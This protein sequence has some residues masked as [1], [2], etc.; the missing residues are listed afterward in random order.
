MESK[1][2]SLDPAQ[3]PHARCWLLILGTIRTT[4]MTS[5]LIASLLVERF[6]ERDPGLS[7]RRQTSAYS[8]GCGGSSRRS[9]SFCFAILRSNSTGCRISPASIMSPMARCASCTTFWSF[10]SATR[11]ALKAYCPRDNPLSRASPISG[12]PRIG[13]S[14]RRTTCSAS[15][16]MGI[17]ICGASFVPTTGRVSFTEGLPIPSGIPRYSRQRRTG[18]ATAARLSEVTAYVTKGWIDK[19]RENIVVCGQ[20]STCLCFPVTI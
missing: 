14:A 9:P 18:L 10:R 7:S 13:M 5:A 2:E 4:S 17:R 8:C 15:F 11:F 6:G 20:I 1:I 12:R 16:S 3:I 19:D